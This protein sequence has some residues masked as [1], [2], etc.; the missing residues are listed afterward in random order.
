MDVRGTARHYSRETYSALVRQRQAPRKHVPS[1]G[2]V[3]AASPYLQPAPLGVTRNAPTLSPYATPSAAPHSRPPPPPP[4][5]PRLIDVSASRPAPYLHVETQWRRRQQQAPP[6]HPQPPP[7]PP[8][9]QLQPQP[10]QLKKPHADIVAAEHAAV[11]RE[12]IQR[13]VQRQLDD[14]ASVAAAAVAAGVA[15]R[16]RVER[17]SEPPAATHP[18]AAQAK[19]A[20]A[21]AQA[22]HMHN[23]SFARQLEEQRLKLMRLERERQL[24]KDRQQQMAAQAQAEAQ[25]EA[26]AAQAQAAQAQAAVQAP[27]PLAPP[28]PAPTAPAPSTA[29]PVPTAPAQTPHAPLQRAPPPPPPPPRTQAAGPLPAERS[30]P[31]SSRTT[32][33]VGS[34]DC[35]RARRARLAWHD[36]APA[37]PADAPASSSSAGASAG[38]SAVARQA[39]AYT[40][41]TFASG[42]AQL[43][44]PGSAGASRSR[45]STAAALGAAAA[46]TGEWTRPQSRQPLQRPSSASATLRRTSGASSPQYGS[47][48][49]GGAHRAQSLLTGGGGGAAAPAAS[50]PRQHP[51]LQDTSA[52]HR[53]EIEALRRRT[54]ALQNGTSIAAR[55]SAGPSGL[56][57]SRPAS[58]SAARRPASASAAGRS[59]GGAALGGGGG[60][61]GG[62]GSGGSSGSSGGGGGSSGGGDRPATAL[63]AHRPAPTRP[64]PNGSGRSGGGGGGGGG[65]G[66]GGDADDDDDEA[67]LDIGDYRRQAQ[68]T[69]ML[70]HLR[71]SASH[72]PA[73]AQV[74]WG[75]L[76]N[77]GLHAAVSAIVRVHTALQATGVHA[78]AEALHLQQQ[79]AALYAAAGVKSGGGRGLSEEQLERIETLH[80]DKERLESL[81]ERPTCGRSPALPFPSPARDSTASSSFRHPLHP[82]R[83]RMVV[84]QPPSASSSFRHPLHPRRARMVVYQPPSATPRSD[85]T[86]RNR[87]QPQHPC[88]SCTAMRATLALA[89]RAA[90]RAWRQAPGARSA[91]VA[92]CNLCSREWPALP[93]SHV[94]S[95]WFCHQLAI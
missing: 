18:L 83:A 55:T 69:L 30:G 95:A 1:A 12:A 70:S 86:T 15:M 58:A 50:D 8:P 52:H 53:A 63:A 68:R 90:C 81:K 62:G 88:R 20:Q 38:A 11:R 67:P 56:P 35:T 19:A 79:L 87:T 31:A 17:P 36:G 85:A 64:R 92:A 61:S 4:A 34:S 6:H 41:H 29:N 76:D 9:P 10:Q 94:S 14:H 25:A 77:Q 33:N 43:L 3:G 82:R 78:S 45:G 16:T 71:E 39:L 91:T 84:Y 73:L 93:P 54:A 32:G 75:Q 37:A 66:D 44:R 23:A 59:S 48:L 49:F 13:Q 28:P 27:P 60:G 80:C 21:Q 22:Q 42:G 7:P 40:A 65:S 47:S 72:F 74:E 2:T 51:P 89:Q 26:T 5:K 46:H 57:W 24:H